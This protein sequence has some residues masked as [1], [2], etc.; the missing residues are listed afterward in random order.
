MYFTDCE[1]IEDVKKLYYDI[2]V[3]E[4]PFDSF[5]E[6]EAAYSRLKNTHRNVN[7]VIYESKKSSSETASDYAEIIDSIIHFVNCEVEII[8][9]W[10]WVS[11]NAWVYREILK[12]LGFRRNSNKNA[13][14]YH[15]EPYR[16]RQG[17]NVSMDD[18]RGKF[19]SEPARA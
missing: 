17:R 11:G 8:G 13:W 1:C 4:Q 9:S 5:S 6:Y 2:A 15:D 18:L 10:V 12:D 3:K 14:A 19:S 16:K 7:G